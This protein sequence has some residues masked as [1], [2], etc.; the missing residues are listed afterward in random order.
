MAISERRYSTGLPFLDRRLGGGLVPGQL[1]AL[2]APPTSQSEL[3]L[4]ELLSA[5]Q[6]MFISTTRPEEEV[7][8][9]AEANGVD[10]DVTIQTANPKAVLEDPTRI[11]D[12][13]TPESFLVVDP[14]DGFETAE[15]DRYLSVLDHL[16]T[17][18]RETESVG[19]LHCI[20][21]Q[22][23]PARRSLTLQ[24]SDYV[25]QVE[26]IILSREIKTRLLV[27]KAR[28]GQ[29]L[30]EPIPLRLTD[31]VQIDTSRRIA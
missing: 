22:Q 4:A 21:Q 29:A 14:H 5:R 16:K 24:R 11:T 10:E 27:T 15:R 19:I 20:D 17:H 3:L 26:L 23:P 30:T 12:S 25:W 6:T 1:L 13:L 2:T 8:L 18:L 7:E 28:R 31:Q 9:W